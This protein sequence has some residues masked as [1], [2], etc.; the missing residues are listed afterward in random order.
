ME[1][2][3][4]QLNSAFFLRRFVSAYKIN[5]TTQ[6]GRKLKTNFRERLLPE[7]ENRAEHND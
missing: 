6:T 3:R 5:S 4:A 7:V 1:F 2:N